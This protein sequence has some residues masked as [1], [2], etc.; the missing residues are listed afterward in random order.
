MKQSSPRIRP[1]VHRGA[2]H[3]SLL[4]TMLVAL[5]LSARAQEPGRE[6]FVPYDQLDAVLSKKFKGVVLPRAQFDELLRQAQAAQSRRE[7]LPAATV[8][9]TASWRVRQ[10]SRHAVIELALDI[11]QF[12]DH[13]TTLGIPVGHLLVESA[14]IDNNPASVGFPVDNPGELTL[15]HRAAG[16]FTLN[17]KLST[18]LGVVGSDRLAA[19]RLIPGVTSTL[20]VEC[21][22]NR[23]VEV[24]DLKLTRPAAE[25]RAT[26]YSIPVGNLENVRLK[27]TLQR[28]ETEMQTL[29]FA[30]S[31][32]PLKLGNDNLRWKST[33]RV[34]VFGN[35]INQLVARVPASLEVTAVDSTG[36]ESWQLEDDPDK[37][38][39]TRV[40]LNFRQPFS[41][42]RLI[43]LSAISALAPD[44]SSA[45]PT[46]EFVNITAHAGRLII[47]H[48]E[49][50]RLMADVGEGIRHLGTGSESNSQPAGEI[51]DFWLQDYQ[52]RVSVRPRDRELFAEINSYL[53]IEDTSAAFIGEMTIESLNDALFELPVNIPDGWQIG[54]VT[55]TENVPLKWRADANGKQIIVTP[56]APIVAGGLFSLKVPLTRQINDPTKEQILPL[57][58]VTAADALTVSGTYE[59]SAADDLI[60]TPTNL[61][62]LS[63]V[64]DDDGVLLYETQGTTWSGSVSVQRQPVRLASRCVIRSWMDT[65]QKTTEAVITADV[66]TG[67]TRMLRISLPEHLGED[68]RFSV[69]SIGQIPGLIRQQVPAFVAIT[70]QTATDAVGGRRTFQLTF[71]RRF[72]GSLTLRTLVRQDRTEE[73]RLSADAIRVDGAVR[74][75][76]LVVF[77]AYPEQQLSPQEGDAVRSGL[78]VADAGLVDPPPERSNRRT[79]LVYR[80]VQPDYSLEI[81]ETRFDTETVPSAVCRLMRNVSV[82]SETGAIQRSCTAQLQC[83]GVQSIRFELPGESSSFLWST[84]LNGE[85]VEVRRDGDAFLV[86]LPAGADAKEHI[87]EVLFQSEAGPSTVFGRTTQTSLKLAIDSDS[88]QALPIDILEQRWDVRYPDS[89]LLIDHD[90]GFEAR[91]DIDRPGWLQNLAANVTLPSSSRLVEGL[92]PLGIFLVALF[93]LTALILRRRWKSLTVVC[94]LGIIGCLFLLSVSQQTQDATSP[95]TVTENSAA[96]QGWDGEKNDYE[97]ESGAGMSGRG[98]DFGAPNDPFGAESDEMVMMDMPEAAE[99]G[100]VSRMMNDEVIPNESNRGGGRQSRSKSEARPQFAPEPETRRPEPQSAPGQSGGAGFAGGGLPGSEV[101]GEAAPQPLANRMDETVIDPQ[102]QQGQGIMM[103]SRGPDAAFGEAPPPN[104]LADTNAPMKG[105]ARLSIRAEIADPDDYQLQGFRSIGAAREAGELRVTVQQKSTLAALRLITATIVVLICIWLNR[106]SVVQRFSVAVVLMA[107]ALACVPLLSGAWQCVADGLALGVI[108]GCIYW[109]CALAKCG[110]MAW[111]AR[112]CGQRSLTL[113]KSTDV[114]VTSLVLIGLCAMSETG[115][116]DPPVTSDDTIKP[117]VILPYSSDGPFALADRVYLSHDEFLKLYRTVNPDG[118]GETQVPQNNGVVAAFYQSGD[119][120]QVDGTTWS[121]SFSARYIIRSYSEKPVSIPLPLGAA[122]IRT[123]TLDGDTALL[124]G[125]ATVDSPEGQQKGQQG[126]GSPADQP[127]VQQP[128]Q[129]PVQQRDS[130][131]TSTP[132]DAVPS[133]YSVHISSA[134]FH[135]LDVT[136]EVAAM[137]ENEVG[138]VT[139]PLRPI[140]AGTLTFELPAEELDVKVNGRSNVG[141]QNGTSLLIPIAKSGT[142]RIDWQPKT[143]RTVTDSVF[144]SSVRSA[145]IVD[146]AGLTLKSSITINARQGELSEVSVVI[147]ED[148]SVQNVKG[149][150][151]AGWN[152]RQNNSRELQL[153]FRE[154]IDASATVDLTLFRRAVFSTDETELSVP[155]PS[156]N[157]ASR[158]SG[159]IT[160]IATREMEIRVSSLS[161]VS[162]IN[163]AE[164]SLPNGMEENVNRVLAWRYTRHPAN[165]A[166]RVFRAADRVTARLLNGVLL[167]SQ[168]Q[169]WTTHV[170]A[171]IEGSPLRILEIEL[172]TD[173]VVLDVSANNLAD[174]YVTPPADDADTK[175]LNIQLQQAVRGRV[176]AVIQ[177]QRGVS[178]DNSAKVVLQV[179]QLSGIDESD[180]H[181]SLWLDRAS[182][183]EDAE[184]PGW[185]RA[186]GAA[187][188]SDALLKLR[189]NA[190]DISF[191]SEHNSGA[192][193]PVT[194]TLGRKAVTLTPESVSVTSVSDTSLE[195]TLGLNWLITNATHEVSFTLPEALKDVFEFRIPGLRQLQVSEPENGRV[196]FTV[197]LQQAVTGRLFILGTGTLSLPESGEIRPQAPEFTVPE[198][199]GITLAPQAHFWVIVNQSAG[200]LTPTDPD[201]DGDDVSPDD[202]QLPEGFLK[203]SVAIRRLRTDRQVSP[204]KL[205]FPARQEVSPAVVTL[206][207]HTTVVAD[208]GTWRSRHQ[209]QVRN[210]SRQFVPVVIPEG[211]RFLYC[212]VD[213]RPTRIV[214]RSSGESIMHLIPV[215]QSGELAAPFEVEF[216]LAGRLDSRTPDINAQTVQ[217]PVPT[218]P[219]FRDDAEF[220]ITVTRNTWSVYLPEGWHATLMDD[221]RRSNVVEADVEDFE[222]A[223]LLSLLDNTKSMINQIDSL[224]SRAGYG[225][226]SDVDSLLSQEAAIQQLRGNTIDA[227]EQRNRALEQLQVLKGNLGSYE[228]SMPQEEASSENPF[229]QQLESDNNFFNATNNDLLY[230]TNAGSGISSGGVD[231]ESGFN[232]IVPQGSQGKSSGGKQASGKDGRGQ[233]GKGQ[234][235]MKTPQKSSGPAK[236]GNRSK[237]LDRR[238]ENIKQ[239]TERLKSKSSER[240]SRLESLF[241]VSSGMGSQSQLNKDVDRE[242]DAQT[243]GFDLETRGEDGQTNAM[244]Q[245]AGGDLFGNFAN[246]ESQEDVDEFAAS[247]VAPTGDGL[248]SLR[249]E[250]PDGGDRYDFVR[251]SG[252]ASLALRIR[253]RESIGTGLG[254]LWAVACA[255]AAIVLLKSRSLGSLLRRV[256]LLACVAGLVGSLCFTSPVRILMVLLCVMSAFGFCVV[257]VIQQYRSPATP[258]AAS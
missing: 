162:Q 237:L 160:V 233:D 39:F 69:D 230:S 44:G 212:I 33:T 57:P 194:V 156:I 17:L 4:V 24:N 105:S 6:R 119:R 153:L 117:D 179:P 31:D 95:A 143:N 108:A 71:D 2:V 84:V 23:H 204:W 19:L 76:G 132:Y 158:D 256:L 225:L 219:E 77:E 110:L 228:G 254:L 128:V 97:Y 29:I 36:L 91:S 79:A 221:P 45:V 229:L 125:T 83:V 174:W 10:D 239:Q 183:I 42:D 131:Q 168:R 12:A 146:N 247:G 249:F 238:G 62:G 111:W 22:A 114:V 127:P 50:L 190:P 1:R 16:R 252:N 137:I 94:T 144:H 26:E 236:P 63:P 165:A 200:L 187:R 51:F 217:V 56:Q 242:T 5:C 234:D 149:D 154:P 231:I 193:G 195:L 107:A 164:S 218:L 55:G 122:A 37:A 180:H 90:G 142:T 133:G 134:G 46:L 202:I 198:D 173:S 38:G 75:H 185:K 255:I 49:Q 20:T 27:W 73:T 147:P 199:S 66:I 52:L 88:G 155:I 129:P 151:L 53:N 189:R 205:S 196:E 235:G 87:L 175:T 21:P 184:A 101:E 30:R 41:D 152:I 157:D 170:A 7:R 102:V 54:M 197:R 222:D 3:R 58:V 241:D 124:T 206:A 106:R 203:Q 35:S 28:R 176:D 192:A 139:L 130:Q 116:A 81:T 86:A 40:I 253:G 34:S 167:E 181:L 14:T 126:A 43:T 213:G 70:E 99:S 104:D 135:T 103:G 121:Q 209:L 177:S 207:A 32:V 120:K 186:R 11:E 159:H 244:M 211:G 93:V 47:S 169:L 216:A 115:C 89:S 100:E 8:I 123:A 78:S 191:I 109:L 82:L 145:L 138:R 215:P 171:T 232:F 227:E 80:Y 224:K 13:W 178:D 18:P 188:V 59:I 182:S 72:A 25:E 223:E 172:P 67:T 246:A 74:Q 248:L 220:G 250:I 98:G 148:Y 163:A 85:A 150:H 15:L 65:R 214:I 251:G 118:L 245:A 141:R 112:C 48:E 68:V 140:P 61:T 64:G 257:L 258:P 208:D 136:F 161:G 60:L 243:F 240:N 201:A 9:R 210:E 92:V 166:I 113:R 96:E 226:A